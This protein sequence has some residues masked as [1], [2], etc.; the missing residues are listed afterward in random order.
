M[1]G[2]GALYLVD[3]AGDAGGPYQG[4]LLSSAGSIGNSQC[5]IAGA[6]SSVSF[7]DNTLTLTLAIPFSHSF[8]GNQVIHAAAR[9]ATAN[10]GWQPLGTI[11]VP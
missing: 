11:T 7:H 3:D 10:S 8:A 9:S 2:T 1:R 6:G 5:S 4:M